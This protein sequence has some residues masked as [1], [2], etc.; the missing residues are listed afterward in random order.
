MCLSGRAAAR[1]VQ[2]K[3]LLPRPL[4]FRS[5]SLPTEGCFSPAQGCTQITDNHMSETLDAVLSVCGEALRTK[6]N[7]VRL[8]SGYFRAPG[9]DSEVCGEQSLF[10]RKIFGLCGDQKQSLG[11]D[12]WFAGV[13]SCYL[14]S[15]CLSRNNAHYRTNV[16]IC[17]FYYYYFTINRN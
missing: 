5:C 7:W 15:Q 13:S 10:S 9:T 17:S 12:I 6:P 1:Q 4:R 11:S 16:T 8:S 2:R 3:I 14:F